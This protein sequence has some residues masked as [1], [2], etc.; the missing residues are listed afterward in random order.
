MRDSSHVLTYA[1]SFRTF[2]SCHPHFLKFCF[3]SIQVFPT[4]HQNTFNIFPALCNVWFQI[5]QII[6]HV[7]M[8][9]NYSR[10]FRFRG[11]SSNN[12]ALRKKIASIFSLWFISC[13]SV[14][15]STYFILRFS[16]SCAI[17]LNRLCVSFH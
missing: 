17:L 9:L 16:H 4:F 7:I 10:S 6:T 3:I 14:L 1:S 11:T 8:K 5:Q 2:S 12:L 13:F 15:L